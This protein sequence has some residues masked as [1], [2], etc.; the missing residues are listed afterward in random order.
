VVAE[1]ED[2]SLRAW[3]R[4]D[5]DGLP[6]GFTAESAGLGTQIV[7]ALVGGDMRGRIEWSTLDGGGTEVSVDVT[8]RALPGIG[9]VTDPT[10][11]LIV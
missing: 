6:E 5:G 10:P 7:Q 11:A 9:T 8:L 3:V 4:D 1:R 2:T